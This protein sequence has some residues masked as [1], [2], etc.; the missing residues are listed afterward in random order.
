M[1]NNLKKLVRDLDFTKVVEVV[2]SKEGRDEFKRCYYEDLWNMEVAIILDSTG[3]VWL[4]GPRSNKFETNSE[5]QGFS[6]SLGAY[7]CNENIVFSYNG[8]LNSLGDE[9]TP[10]LREYL[11]LYTDTTTMLS[12]K[13]KELYPVQFDE[14]MEQIIGF[15]LNYKLDFLLTDI[16]N[17][18]NSIK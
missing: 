17:K 13:C 12:L 10:K 6:I 3:E 18:I 15:R 11:K 1:N 4:S 8:F 5:M 7:N 14:Y 2:R 9:N 16:N